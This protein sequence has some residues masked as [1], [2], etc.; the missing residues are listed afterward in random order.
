MNPR[1][2]IMESKKSKNKLKEKKLNKSIS[3]LIK[4]PNFSSNTNYKKIYSFIPKTSYSVQTSDR[5]PKQNLANKSTYNLSK[6]YNLNLYRQNSV[7][8]LCGLKK[9]FHDLYYLDNNHK[10]SRLYKHI[11]SEVKSPK[12]FDYMNNNPNKKSHNHH[13]SQNHNNRYYENKLNHKSSYYNKSTQNSFAFSNRNKNLS[14]RNIN[15]KLKLEEYYDNGIIKE[16]GYKKN[17][18]KININEDESYLNKK[19]YG[20]FR[21][22]KNKCVIER[23]FYGEDK[24]HKIKARNKV[25]EKEEEKD[26]YIL[27]KTLSG[28]GDNECNKLFYHRSRLNIKR[29]LKKSGFDLYNNYNKNSNSNFNQNPK[30]DKN[31]NINKLI[32]Y[33]LSSTKMVLNKSKTNNNILNT[34]LEEITQSK[35]HN[36]KYSKQIITTNNNNNDNNQK[37]TKNCRYNDIK[38]IFPSFFNKMDINNE[39][40]QE[41]TN[42]I[43]NTFS[44]KITINNS[45][46]GSRKEKFINSFLDGPE[47]IHCRFVDLHRQ[48]KIFY[49]SMCNKNNE[50]NGNSNNNMAKISDFDKNEYSEYFDNFNEDVP[51]I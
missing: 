18:T 43:G 32:N 4:S 7:G 35:I 9:D 22:D 3:L 24:L 19:I 10:C 50:N 21:Y 25:K 44:N 30:K 48:R 46:I 26:L 11:L 29:D 6:L 5:K 49:E 23:K 31:L 28:I 33:N 2:K 47:D 27:T 42:L 37:E 15:I 16:N 45:N 12:I 20:N 38:L 39:S 36:N 17:K 51:I 1:K 34:S 13:S 41:S 40:S 14:Q 8:S